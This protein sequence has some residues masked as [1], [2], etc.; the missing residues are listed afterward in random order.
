V[1][2][3]EFGGNQNVEMKRKSRTRQPKTASYRSRR[4]TVR[5]MPDKQAKDVKAGLLS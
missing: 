2:P 4:K 5:G 3:D 1:W